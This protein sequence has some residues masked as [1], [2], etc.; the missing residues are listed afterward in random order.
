MIREKLRE[1][2]REALASVLPISIIVLVLCATIAPISNHVFVMFLVGA[3]FLIVGMGVF[4]LGVDTAMSPMGEN[5]GANMTK[6]RKVWLIAFLSFVLGVIVTVSEPDLQVLA[7]Q[8]SAVP[9]MVLILAVA[10]GVGLFLCIAMMRSLFGVPLKYLLILFYT[11]VFVLAYFA[12]RE[13]LPV[14]FDAGGVTTGPMTVPFIMAMG[15]GVVS[16]RS[17]SRASDD[18]FGLVALSSIGP[19][20][21]VMILGIVFPVDAA[22][23]SAADLSHIQNTRD[24]SLTFAEN[25]PHYLGEVLLSLL[26]LCL[27][28][29]LFQVFTRSMNRKNILKIVIGLAYTM[30][31]LLLF[32]TGANVGFM[33]A[34]NYIGETIGASPFAWLLVP[35]GMIVGYFVVKAEPAVHVLNKQVAQLTL[36]E[37]SEKAMGTSMSVGVALSVGLSMIRI[38]TGI[39]VMWF[40]IPGYALALLLLFVCPRMF[41]AIAFDSGGVA[42]GTMTS[43]FLLSF[44]IGACRAL[45][46]NVQTD[47]FGLVALVAMTP[48]LTIQLLGMAYKLKMSD[49]R[50]PVSARPVFDDEIVAL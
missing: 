4:S 15:V 35:I 39:S 41:S 14:A 6:S 11:A 24:I 42:S 26:P 40:L 46:G 16:I 2:W 33:P 48:L 9:N 38:L 1:K 8:V 49:A 7:Q 10:I 50:K 47:A 37:I 43:T 20:L 12:P 27:F 45:G 31:G 32:L 30:V 44:A 28:F 18:S 25:L 17:D 29:T 5:T 36:G 13:F 34:G 3:A 22:E 23:E 21:A 19:I